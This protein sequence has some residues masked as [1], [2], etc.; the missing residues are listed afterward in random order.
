MD[1]GLGVDKQA[2]VGGRGVGHQHRNGE[3]ADPAGA[4]LLLHIPLV[5]G[6]HQPADAGADR[7]AEAFGFGEVV[8]AEP[9]AGIGPGLA[10]GDDGQLA[11]PV[12]PPRLHPGHPAGQ[13][14]FHRP[15]DLHGQFRGPVGVDVADAAA[16]VKQGLPSGRGV[17]AE[18]GDSAE[19]GDHDVGHWMFSL[20]V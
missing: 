9:E 17:V 12:H 3:R 1:A 14:G 8:L 19:S 20:V 6:G 15:G 13:V 16:S 5:E 2:D 4:L 11:D 18:R 7:D 10:G